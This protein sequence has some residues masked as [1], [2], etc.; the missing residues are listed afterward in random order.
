MFGIFVGTDTIQ[1]CDG[2][3]KHPD[4]ST[5][6]QT[7]VVEKANQKLIHYTQHNVRVT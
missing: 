5:Q 7:Q 1:I 3:I 4:T 6:T 2:N